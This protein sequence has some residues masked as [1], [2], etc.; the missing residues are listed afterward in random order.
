[1]A[2]KNTAIK[3]VFVKTL[4][5]AACTSGCLSTAYAQEAQESIEQGQ[6]LEEIVVYGYAKSLRNAIET[7][8]N[9]D[10]II[11]SISAE[12]LGKL[13]DISVADSL[14]RLPGVTTQ[15]T[16]GQA[17]RINIRG[18]DEDL[19]I[20]TLNGREQA[21]TTGS[22]AIDFSQYPSEL[23]A[24][25]DVYKSSQAN[26]IEGGLAGTVELKI[27]RPLD[28]TLEKQHNYSVNLR[29]S[30]NDRA[31]DSV[32]SDEFGYRS[33]FTYQ[34]ILAD[35]TIG[36]TLGYA[37]LVQPNSSFRFGTDIFT[38]V[39]DLDGNGVN[40][41]IPFRYGAEELGGE[42]QRDSFVA[43][44][45]FR[46]NDNLEFAFD[47]FYSKFESTGFA[48]G[49]TLLGPQSI[50]DGGTTIT[51]AVVSNDVVVGGTF[52]REAASPITDPTDP[53]STGACCGGFGITPSSDTQTRDFDNEL[54][55][56]GFST[57]WENGPWKV[58]GDIS[59][60]ESEA[61]QPDT[62]VIIHQVNNGFQLE[63]NVV[64]N[65][66][67]NELN[68]PDTFTFENNF[69]SNP[70]QIAV[71]AFQ[72]FPTTNDDELIALA[73]SVEY[74][75]EESAF[76]SVEFGVRYSERT[77]SQFREGFAVGNEAGFF[78]FA[79]NND[80]AGIENPN[81]FN[82]D[83]PGFSP[84]F[85][86]PSLFNVE[87]FDGEFSG[88]PNFLDI[89]FDAVVD[90]FPNLTPTQQANRTAAVAGGDINFL[91]TDTYE[92]EEETLAAFAQ[93]NFESEL[94]GLPVRG[95]VGFRYVDTDQSSDS[96]TILNSEVLPIS[97]SSG[98]DEVL[99][100][101]NMAISATDNLQIRI[102]AAKVIAR[103]DLADL[104]A[105]NS[106][107]VDSTTGVVSGTGGNTNL[108][109]FEANQI[110]LSVEYY[111]ENGGIYTAA[112]FY[113][114]L[115]TFIFNS[116]EEINF[117]DQGFVNPNNVALNP[118]VALDPIGL[119]NAPANG[120][121][122]RVSGIELAFTQTFD[123][124]P[125]P[126]NGLGISANYSYTDSSIELPDT[127]S[128]RGD[129]S[130]ALPGLSENVFNATVFYK[131]GGFET[132]IGYRFR[133]EF[134]S[135]QRGIGEQL[136]V[137]GTE[138]IYDFQS[139]Y[140]FADGSRYEGLTLLFQVDN[141]TDEAF[142]NFFN[143]T[144]QLSSNALFGRQIFLGASYNF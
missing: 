76:T 15:R 41:L 68:V 88:F 12:D 137:T 19:V 34:G 112:I 20:S 90:L 86:D 40:E 29:G 46:P 18:L 11:E 99:P 132:R 26:L 23:I 113:K 106:I 82:N 22:R 109:P 42:D 104:R 65:I 57:I 49:V 50:S 7:K 134:I 77:S 133:D 119:F 4:I 39:Q 13:P 121:G 5:A 28:A 107:N 36:L 101:F 16:S 130:I 117:V 131:L 127:E 56:L 135:R 10:K 102:A 136:P 142:T 73:S 114:D 1:M 111:T 45:Q 87:E 67:L 83:L 126:F 21:A 84:V 31:G 124:L 51:N 129:R 93:L 61:F 25:A 108:L 64:F 125:V 115:D 80:D 14:S 140:R 52:T 96:N 66:G 141:V 43:S 70:D 30:F 75:F 89:D 123:W 33:S 44:L 94:F 71:G 59:Y 38:E 58:K 27:G 48:R 143:S 81:P 47:A 54:I 92:V 139:S 128:G 116:S 3:N 95:N 37:R 100:S 35:E 120:E 138:S 144:E 79:R 69:G 2:N 78:Q 122:G 91:L 55:T 85:L 8:R 60:S 63:D 9:D 62:R 105:G 53:F 118:G 72:S 6:Q 17:G 24:G 103:A 97:I 98:Y 110:D 32:D 74:A